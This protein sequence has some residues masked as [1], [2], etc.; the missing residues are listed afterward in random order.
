MSRNSL[1]LEQINSL[2]VDWDRNVSHLKYEQ[3]FLNL[4]ECVHVTKP[5]FVYQIDPDVNYLVVIHE[6]QVKTPD[7]LRITFNGYIHERVSRR[8]LHFL[9]I[10][11]EEEFEEVEN[12]YFGYSLAEDLSIYF[13]RISG[14]RISLE[15]FAQGLLSLHLVR[16]V[17]ELETFLGRKIG[18]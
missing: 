3:D 7:S 8:S 15:S 1:F 13:G 9:S 17:R 5:I 12:E 10:L 4:Q 16:E 18:H 11:T 2:K 14:K 6:L